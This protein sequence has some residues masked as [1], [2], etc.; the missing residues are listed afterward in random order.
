M[1]KAY[2]C[3]VAGTTTLICAMTLLGYLLIRRIEKEMDD[4]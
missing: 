1:L 4:V 3:Y 2:L